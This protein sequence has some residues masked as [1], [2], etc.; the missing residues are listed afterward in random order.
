VRLSAANL[1]ATARL[2]KEKG[3]GSHRALSYFAW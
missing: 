1:P 2:Q 3:R